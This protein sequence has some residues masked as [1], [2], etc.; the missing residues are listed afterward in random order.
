MTDRIDGGTDPAE[1][2]DFMAR[3]GPAYLGCGEQTANIEALLRRIALAYGMREARVVA[4]PTGIFITLHDGQGERTTL[5]EGPTRAMRLDQIG[6]IYALG[7]RAQRGE[8]APRVGLQELAEILLRRERFGRTGQVLG[9]TIMAAGVGMLLQPTLISVAV[10]AVLGLIVGLVKALIKGPSVAALPMPVFVAALVSFLVFYAQREGLPVEPIHALIPPLLT[11]LPGGTLTLGMVELAYGDMVSGA[12]RLITGLVQ[13]ILLAFGLAAGAAVLGAKP[14]DLVQSVY[15]A[16]QLAWT[17]WVAV[18]LFG[19]GVFMHFSAPRDSL[20]WLL[21]VLLAASGSQ[22][23]AAATFGGE[24]SG[25]FGMLVATPLAYLIQIQFKGPPA[26]V[27]FLP[28]FW[29]VVPGALG[30]LS[31][32]QML[33]D[34][35]AGIEGMA[36]VVF[37]VTSVALGTLVGASLYRLASERL[38][39]MIRRTRRLRLL[40]DREP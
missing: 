15:P 40:R 18:L 29:I 37:V 19:I 23:L 8:L 27:T 20:P 33:S 36:T 11:Y 5:A 30:L 3:L 6:A 21:L 28:G 22:R 7:E 12:S 4:F 31:V 10:A 17:P 35:A 25:F 34:R 39:R 1:L 2:L 16:V 13:L 24:I 38:R 32:T 9:H 26:M 14:D